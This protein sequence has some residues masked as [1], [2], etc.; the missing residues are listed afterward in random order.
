MLF[1]NILVIQQS[2]V[3]VKYYYSFLSFKSSVFSQMQLSL[4]IRIIRSLRYQILYQNYLKP[5]VLYALDY[6]GQRGGGIFCAVVHED[7]GAVG[8]FIE[9]GFRFQS[10]E[11]TSHCTQYMPSCFT[12]ST[13]LLS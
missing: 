1:L 6:S 4:H 13:T 9:H 11:S 7:D 12:V 8:D 5:L 3:K 10:K 2:N